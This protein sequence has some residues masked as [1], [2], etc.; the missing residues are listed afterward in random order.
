VVVIVIVAM[1][2]GSYNSLVSSREEVDRQ[3]ANIESSLQRRADLIPNL[4]GAVQGAFN[5]EQA[6]F[7]EIARA[8]AALVSALG[9]G[10][11]AAVNTAN[12]SLTSALA[13]LN[14]LVQNEAYPQLRSNEQVQALMAEL[15]GTENR[16]NVARGDYNNAVRQYNQA[17]RSF[18]TNII[19]GMMGFEQADYFEA[20]P[21]AKQAPKV[22]F[23]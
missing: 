5:Q 2:A 23:K 15:A 22:E 4:V 14:V 10:D 8:R 18:P 19:A 1:V 9:S 6:V 12:N 11:R 16:I 7:G 13:G 21:A 17:I 20:D 3:W